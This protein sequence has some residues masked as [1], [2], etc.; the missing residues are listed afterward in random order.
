MVH[1]PGL[2]NAFLT[3]A[4]GTGVSTVTIGGEYKGSHQAF[5]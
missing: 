2:R 1:I 5:R 3:L 4:T